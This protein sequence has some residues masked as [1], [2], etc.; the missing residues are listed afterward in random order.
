MDECS[1]IRRLE[2]VSIIFRHIDDTLTIHEDFLRF[3]ETK[4][5]L[6]KTLFKIIT[7]VLERFHLSIRSIVDQCF[8]RAANISGEITGLKTRIQEVNQKALFVHWTAH[9]LNLVV[10]DSLSNVFDVRDFIGTVKELINFVCNS[11]NHLVFFSDLQSSAESIENMSLPGLKA[12]CL[13]RLYLKVSSLITVQKNYKTL[14]D[15]F[16]HVQ[17][18]PRVD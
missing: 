8:E 14:I 10:Q 7:D 1:D 15:F 2:Q 16:D 9:K 18:N 5:T 3:Y 11:P 12:Y 13:T 6:S 17:N 4:N